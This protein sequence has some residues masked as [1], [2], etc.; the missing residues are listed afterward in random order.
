MDAGWVHGFGHGELTQ[1]DQFSA[2][3]LFTGKTHVAST[4]TS[5]ASKGGSDTKVTSDTYTD[6]KGV[7]KTARPDAAAIVS[8]RDDT[9]HAHLQRTAHSTSVRKGDTTK[10]HRDSIS[11]LDKTDHATITGPGGTTTVEAKVQV[12]ASASADST[13]VRK[14]DTTKTQG[15]STSDVDVTKH[16]TITAPNGAKTTV[17]SHK[18]VDAKSTSDSTVKSDAKSVTTKSGDDTK[19]VTNATAKGS[20]E[21][22]TDFKV[23]ADGKIVDAHGNT[24]VLK[25]TGHGDVIA[26]S[27]GSSKSAGTTVS[28]TVR[29][30]AETDVTGKTVTT[31]SS[32]SERDA[33]THYEGVLSSTTSNGKTTTRYVEY[34][35]DDDVRTTATTKTV[36]EFSAESHAATA[37][38][39]KAGATVTQTVDATADSKSVIA[40]QRSDTIR[41]NGT[42][43]VEAESERDT[44][45][46]NT[47][48]VVTD[49]GAVV[50][51][52]DRTV[53]GQ[54][55]AETNTEATVKTTSATAR[56]GNT[57]VQA[58][59]RDTDSHSETEAT[60]TYEAQTSSTSSN[61]ASSTRT[62]HVS[63]ETDY[64]VVRYIR[65][66]ATVRTVVSDAAA[67]S[68]SASA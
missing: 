25:E 17:D 56:V 46:T 21:S 58:V 8:T 51:T 54:T 53:K 61:G 63:S 2:I 65:Y 40:G 4:T 18:D 55:G 15:D 30:G 67:H 45:F 11:A 20:G 19:T 47:V 49:N 10:T 33:V 1:K 24:V 34:T 41:A 42:D 26:I 9:I 31:A 57:T 35:I 38:S 14:G 68:F 12:D 6:A 3:Q 48:H 32:Q 22:E 43:H 66:V 37:K 28:E 52:T 7:T 44:T 36:D 64:D 29:H 60:T 59:S 23:T 13:A 62:D 16:V 5:D 50:T 39:G 27:N